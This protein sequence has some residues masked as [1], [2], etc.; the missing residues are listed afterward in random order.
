VSLQSRAQG[1]LATYLTSCVRCRQIHFDTKR[2]GD[3]VFDY[4]PERYINDPI[5]TADCLNLGD[6]EKRDH[7]NYG[8]GR[9]VCAG[10]HVAQNSMFIIMA[11]TM[12][13]FNIKKAT[14]PDGTIIEVSAKIEPGFIMLPSR[15]NVILEPRSEHHATLIEK[16]WLHSQAAG[17]SFTR[18]KRGKM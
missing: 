10:I 7:F 6:A 14:R 5:S 3:D 12:W 17:L 8:A 15:Q 16:T 2:W 18:A 9:R 11:R 4:N 1:Y 13:G